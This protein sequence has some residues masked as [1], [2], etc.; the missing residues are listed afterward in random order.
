[1]DEFSPIEVYFSSSS[2]HTEVSSQS[3]PVDFDHQ[4][5]YGSSCVI[6]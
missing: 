3:Q 6:T 4:Y 2:S 5:D 1:M